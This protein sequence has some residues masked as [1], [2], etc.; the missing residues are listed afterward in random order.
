M[1]LRQGS[2][3]IIS[4]ASFLCMSTAQFHKRSV[5]ALLMLLSIALVVSHGGPSPVIHSAETEHRPLA[6]LRV[7]AHV[8]G[9]NAGDSGSNEEPATDHSH[10][11]ADRV[12]DVTLAFWNRTV[13]KKMFGR[14]AHD[15]RAQD[16]LAELMRPPT[17]R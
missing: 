4:K 14:L 15:L 12:N 7:D 8:D 2:A 13:R 5:R 17:L 11:P 1:I 6:E 9:A 16:L 10:M 3:R